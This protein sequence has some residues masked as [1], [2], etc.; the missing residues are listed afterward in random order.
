M[1]VGLDLSINSTGI[2]VRDDEKNGE[3]L[4]YY[5][6]VSKVT[7]KTLK[8]IE[9]N[10]LKPLNI[11]VYNKT[12]DINGNLKQIGDNIINILSQYEVEKIVIEDVALGATH[13]RSLI[14]LT[15]LNYWVRCL[16]MKEGYKFETIPPT[17]WKKELLGN[18]QATKDI[19]TDAWK[20]IT[21]IS[22]DYNKL[23]DVADSYF[24]S[25]C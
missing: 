5:L 11:I 15:G 3:N 2:T 7:N 14:D 24:L 9:S 4:Y 10:E 13:S 12:E 23:D 25:C 6:I 8:K 21:N 20:R 22:I 16:L 18:G 17:K 19:I 1:I